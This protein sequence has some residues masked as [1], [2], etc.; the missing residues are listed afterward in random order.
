MG[1]ALSGIAGGVAD[2]FGWGSGEENRTTRTN[3]ES[4]Q[5][6]KLAPETADDIAARQTSTR[7]MQDLDGYLQQ[8]FGNASKNS[9]D[10]DKLFKDALT[11]YATGSSAPTPEEL[12]N[13]TDF[14]DQTFTKGAQTQYTRFLDEAQNRITDRAASLGRSST[15]LGY[16]REFASEAGRAAQ[17]LSDQR[18]SMIA[19]RADPYAKL[20]GLMQGAQYFNTPLQQAIGNRLALG[21]YATGLQQMGLGRRQYEG[22]LTS[23]GT[24]STILPEASLGTRLTNLGNNWAQADKNI[25]SWA[26]FGMGAG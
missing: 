25:M 6:G 16:Q 14:I 13:A 26:K 18:G 5:T 8:I 15:D 17:D 3:Q 7:T 22:T 12:Q 4:S 21:N 2:V 1:A 9:Q 11:R 23:K 19:Q 10:I 20:G 24:G